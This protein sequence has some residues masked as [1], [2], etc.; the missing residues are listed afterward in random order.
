MEIYGTQQT[1]V[2]LSYFY[3]IGHFLE[4]Y[5]VHP[6]VKLKREAGVETAAHQGQVLRIRIRRIRMLLGLLVPDPDPVVRG[7]APAPYPSI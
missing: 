2:S 1:S 4:T 6:L 3:I 7:T 5:I